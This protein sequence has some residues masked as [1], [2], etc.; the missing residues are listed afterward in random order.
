MRIFGLDGDFEAFERVMAEALRREP[1]TVLSS[2]VTPNQWHVLVRPGRD[3]PRTA[4]FRRLT[5][6]HTTRRRVARRGAGRWTGV[7]SRAS[8]SRTTPAC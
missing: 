8:R 1:V 3:G 4:Y 7:G 2:C 6:T 5:H